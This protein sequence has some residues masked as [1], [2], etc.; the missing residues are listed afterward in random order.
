MRGIP[1][2][3]ALLVAAAGCLTPAPDELDAAAADNAV[4]AEALARAT[5][6]GAPSW[7][8]LPA[9]ADPAGALTAFAWTVPAGALV[10]WGYNERFDEDRETLVLE[11]AFLGDASAWG[12]L[13][14]TEGEGLEQTGGYLAVPATS[15]LYGAMGEQTYEAEVADTGF[16]HLGFDIVENETLRFLVFAQGPAAD[17]ALAFRVMD[18]DPYT[19][20]E[21]DEPVGTAQKFLAARGDAPAQTLVPLATATGAVFDLYL[22]ALIGSAL[23]PGV[24][25]ME[26]TMGEPDVAW[27]STRQ[28]RAMGR[29]S[30]V[31]VATPGTFGRGF[32]AIW[33][34]AYVSGVGRSASLATTTLHGERLEGA[35][36]GIGLGTTGFLAGL[37]PTA[38]YAGG[39][40]D[41]DGASGA[42]LSHTRE[43]A[44]TDFALVSVSTVELAAT[45]EDLFAVESQREHAVK[46]ED[47]LAGAVILHESGITL[48]RDGAART[49][50]LPPMPVPHL[51]LPV[52]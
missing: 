16:A 8:L 14:F 18:H 47:G 11:L 51:A 28:E 10:P 46:A 52:P 20:D 29:P 41:G 38:L 2:L 3:A 23:L 50:A 36:G 4:V 44:V 5:A 31:E 35:A 48:Y 32:A 49:F 42:E 45:L 1:L 30:S 43:M 19:W 25:G 13:A 26:A 6:G 27:S 34:D 21:H 7:T 33:A 15:I 39:W 22:D 9:R 24:I 37:R 40:G 17:A 12:L